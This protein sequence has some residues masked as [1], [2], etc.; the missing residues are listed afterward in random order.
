MGDVALAYQ[1]NLEQLLVLLPTGTADMQASGVANRNTKQD[2]KGAFLCFNLN[3][4][5]P[6]ACTTGFLPAQQ[7]RSTGVEDYPAAA[8]RR[9]LLPGAAGLRRSTCAVPQ[10]PMRDKARQTGADGG[11]V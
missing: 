3:L 8:G 1:P 2:Y 4:N 10:H 5:L 6:P 7:Q 11:D 9:Y